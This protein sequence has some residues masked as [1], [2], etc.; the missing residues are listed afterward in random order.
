MPY[1]I[2]V[3]SIRNSA[4]YTGNALL[5]LFF[6][7]RKRS[8]TV[9]HMAVAYI[10]TIVTQDLLHNIVILSYRNPYSLMQDSVSTV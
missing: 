3:S 9:Y 7:K 10:V 8:M 5:V 1:S 2:I 4:Y 6:F